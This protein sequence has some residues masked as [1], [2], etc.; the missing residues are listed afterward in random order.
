MEASAKSKSSKRMEEVQILRLTAMRHAERSSLAAK[1]TGAARRPSRSCV[2]HALFKNEGLGKRQGK[3]E[4]D[5]HD[6][7]RRRVAGAEELEP[8]GIHCV[9]EDLGRLVRAS[10]GECLYRVEHL[11]CADRRYDDHEKRHRTEHRPGHQAEA[12]PCIGYAV[13]GGGFVEMLRDCHE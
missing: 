6:R 1:A 2:V 5:E 8:L 12:F 7:N 13:E 11:Q 9:E 10:L 3:D 4:H